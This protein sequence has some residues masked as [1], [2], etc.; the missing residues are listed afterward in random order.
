MP[1]PTT[2]LRPLDDVIGGLHIGDNV[3]LEAEED[4]TTDEFVSAFVRASAGTAGLAYVSFHVPPTVI[5]DR[6]QAL[7]D[8]RRFVL[9]DCFTDG[10][11]GSD[12]TFGRFYR[13][14]RARDL[15]V[16]RVRDPAAY[17][18]VSA[19]MAELEDGSGPNTRY[20][21]DSLTG[22][23]QLWGA[24]PALSFFLR[25]CPRLYDLRTV[26]YWLLEREAHDPSF[27]SRLAHVT[28]VVLELRAEDGGYALK[29]VKAEGRPSDVV[30]RKAR[31]EF[32]SGRQPRLVRQEQRDG[33]E[34][35]GELLRAQ[36]LARGMTQAQL[37]RRIGISPSALSQAER[38]RAGLSGSTLT[39]AWEV[40][41]AAF[42]PRQ[43]EAPPSYR[44]AHRG[45]RVSSVIAPGLRAEEVADT[46]GGTRVFLLT[47]APGAIG[48]RPPFATK[49]NEAVVVVAG[50]LEAR[51]GE[52]REALQ[53][54]DALV[55]SHEPMSGWKNPGREETRLL[56]IV[57]P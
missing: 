28:Q 50:V 29:V 54:G 14:R 55:L 32:K 24:E 52:A 47:L 49:H 11:G 9:V 20:V 23:Q 12:A 57:A 30:G 19:T 3:V 18:R 33:R 16:R 46:P 10:L 7:W 45:A 42:G 41:G 56:W 17:D 38:G 51:I 8:P 34:R 25:S 35:I 40:L 4:T 36:R 5:L 21:F 26:A 43:P 53:A 6:L 31:L 2:G 1:R 13:S 22:M 37:A 39:R 27:L 44:V 48:R 15:Q